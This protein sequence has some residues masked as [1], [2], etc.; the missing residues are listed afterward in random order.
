MSPD[1]FLDALRAYCSI[2]GASVTSFGRT[3][4]HNREVGGVPRSAHIV[5]LAADVV[6]DADR[7]PADGPEWAGRLGL[8]LIREG[9]HD[10]LQPLDW[11]KG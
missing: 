7:P 4:E 9:D 8:R 3:W 1:Q 11:R 6:Y 10:H 2:T 5:W